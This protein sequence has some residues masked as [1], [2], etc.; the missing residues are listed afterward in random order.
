MTFHR[1]ILSLA[2]TFLSLPLLARGEEIAYVIAAATA[3]PNDAPIAAGSKQ[4]TLRD[5]RVK[6]V[7]DRDGSVHWDKS[8][9]LASGF[10]V[11]INV[12]REPSLS[13]VGLLIS[14]PHF[15]IGLSWNWFQAEAGDIY[16]QLKSDS[17]IRVLL[18]H[19]G[20]A[21]EIVA[22][23]FLDDATLTFTDNMLKRKPGEDTHTILI[24][25]GSV[26]RVAS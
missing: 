6:E 2:I 3:K 21:E 1:V 7:R 22:V 17:R 5:V 13:G 12:T 23:E 4:Y 14:N 9:E 11:G 25:K 19:V 8:V 16:K 20:T 26:L 18:Q 15:P 24:R 10:S